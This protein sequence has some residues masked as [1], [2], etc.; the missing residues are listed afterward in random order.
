MLKPE[1]PLIMCLNTFLDVA[2]PLHGPE[3]NPQSNLPQPF[4]F[5]L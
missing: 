3:L 2:H 5:V 1:L 4:N